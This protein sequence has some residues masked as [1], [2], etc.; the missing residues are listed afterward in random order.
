[1]FAR[2]WSRTG[3]AALIAAALVCAAAATGTGT[4]T[5]IPPRDAVTGAWSGTLAG[6]IRLVLH[7]ERDSTGA[8]RA[9]VDS[10]DQGAMGLGVDAIEVRG[11]SLLFAMRAIGGSY[12]GLID[13]KRA[14]IE[15][16]W[17][18]GDAELPLVLH[19]LAPGEEAAKPAR[20]QEPKPPLPYDAIEV[21]Y[22]NP[23]APGVTLAGTL[24]VPR[25]PGSFPCAVLITG[26]GPED[27]DETVFGHRPFL[28]LADHLTREGIAVL[29]SDDRG[30]GAST[31][32]AARA[33]SEDFAGDVRAAVAYLKTRKEI[34]PARIGLIGHSEG[35]L[36]APMVASRDASV[37]FL[38]LLAGPGVP[39][40]SLLVTQSLLVSR[41]EG[42]SDSLARE[43][44]GTQRRLLAAARSAPDSAALL[45]TMREVIGR[46][47][48]RLPE[49]QR[50]AVGNI[51]ELAARQV[52][53]LRSPWM[54]FFLSYDP[55]PALSRVS[56][57]VL[58]LNGGKD[59]QVSAEQNLP[60]IRAAL[61]KGENRDVTVKTL[62]GLNHLFQTSAT[63]AVGEYAAIEETFAPSAL[64]EISRWIGE[65][66][67]RGEPGGMPRRR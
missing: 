4:T 27:R 39:G 65:R 13:A 40:D 15:G 28:V 32:S 19:P 57:P 67:L 17:R 3:R 43:A 33:T 11:D 50:G 38:V 62:E 14:G 23:D 35:G 24:T 64:E 12:A 56:C 8:L 37:A 26:S 7:V 61:E 30:V 36:I 6:R 59:V 21:T 63:G 20:S 51:D 1:M 46:Q 22:P 16:V 47:I 34:D 60:E 25:S 49:E 58:A 5:G 52:G 9:S 29:R 2:T 54:R 48:A 18:Q 31:G 44:E 53:I 55:R 45:A 42:F 66:T 41:S 10:P